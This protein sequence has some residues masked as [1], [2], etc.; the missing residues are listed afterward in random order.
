MIVKLFK[1]LIFHLAKRFTVVSLSESMDKFE[2]R[3]ALVWFFSDGGFG[4]DK[5]RGWRGGG[6]SFYYGHF[7]II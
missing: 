4:K 5:S 2:Q 1:D 3:L 7:Y 6:R